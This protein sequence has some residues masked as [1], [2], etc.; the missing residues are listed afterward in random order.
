[1]EEFLRTWTMEPVCLSSN[2]S[3]PDV[4]LKSIIYTLLLLETFG[5]IELYKFTFN[6][7]LL[8]LTFLGC[9]WKWSC[10][11]TLHVDNLLNDVTS[12]PIH[13]EEGSV[14]KSKQISLKRVLTVVW[15]CFDSSIN[16]SVELIF[17]IW[18]ICEK[19]SQTHW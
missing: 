15:V 18:K 8:W 19:Q 4:I 7:I 12:V 2:S 10:T 13:C 5:K 17:C 16:W 1:M 6:I 11:N 14:H 3:H 9:F